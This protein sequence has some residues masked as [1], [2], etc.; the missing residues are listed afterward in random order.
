MPEPAADS[1]PITFRLPRLL[2]ARMKGAAKAE[3]R[4]V[5]ELMADAM[6]EKL[7]RMEAERGCPYEVEL[8]KLKPTG[9]PRKQ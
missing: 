2:V 4:K 7:D 9:R 6:R 3:G 5:G 1:E 8:G